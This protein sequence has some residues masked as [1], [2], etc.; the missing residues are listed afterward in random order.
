M[1]QQALFSDPEMNERIVNVASVPHRSPFRYAGGKTWLVPRMRQW[2]LSLPSKPSVLVEPFAG[3][4]IISL[5]AIFDGLVERAVMVELDNEIAAVWQTILSGDAGWLA[6]EIVNFDLTPESVNHVLT[7][8]TGSVRERAFRTILKNRTYHG[9]ILAP[10]SGLIKHGENG[11]GLRSRWY[12]ETLGKRILSIAAVRDRIE[13]IEGDGLQAIRDYAHRPDVVFFVDPPYTAGGKRAGK[14]L[15]TH[16]DLDH[17]E[18]FW[19][20]D[21]TAGDFLMTYDATDGVRELAQQHNF[22][23]QLISMKNTHHAK[24]TELLIGRC[25]DWAR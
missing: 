16:F 19:A 18:L 13:F 4:G 6:A 23:T 20:T 2:L 7:N 24:M 1:I 3:G 10:G 15:Y 17:E 25:L 12:P 22:D 8:Y 9:G 21:A 11:R 5:S 14:R